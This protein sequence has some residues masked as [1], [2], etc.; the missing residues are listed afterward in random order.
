MN[1]KTPTEPT[2]LDN[3]RTWNIAAK[4]PKADWNK[5]MPWRA[6]GTSIPLD[7]CGIASGFLPDA[8]VQYPH[9]FSKESNVK[10]GDKGTALPFLASTTW[11]QGSTVK[12]AF[13]LVVNHGGG[14][15]YR[16]SLLY[17]HYHLY[18]SSFFVLL[19]LTFLVYFIYTYRSFILSFYHFFFF[20]FFYITRCVQPQ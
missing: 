6:P 9:Q 11:T 3:E 13:T 15:Q 10:Q 8:A 19:F 20:I 1:C 16:V 18:S 2:I 7:S 12:A 17:I 4:S 14:Y 5:Y